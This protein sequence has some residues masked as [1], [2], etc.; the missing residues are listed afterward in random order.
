MKIFDIKQ[1][2]KWL[3]ESQDTRLVRSFTHLI[4]RSH[5]GQF[6]PSVKRRRES[7]KLSTSSKIMVTCKQKQNCS[8]CEMNSD[9]FSAHVLEE[10]TDQRLYP[11][12]VIGAS[13]LRNEITL[14][15]FRF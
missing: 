13:S 7:P 8:L 9:V 11:I 10:K 15:V 1:M 3:R 4:D 5:D 14:L 12:K 2:R 6:E